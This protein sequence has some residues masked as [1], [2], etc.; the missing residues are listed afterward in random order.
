MKRVSYV[1]GGKE[2]YERV[3]FSKKR[4]YAAFEAVDRHK[5]IGKRICPRLVPSWESYFETWI[6]S[7]IK[8]GFPYKRSFD[9]G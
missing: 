6:A 9:V 2:L 7:A 4:K 5:A 1:P 8:T 3:C